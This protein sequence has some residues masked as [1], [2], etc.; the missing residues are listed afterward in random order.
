MHDDR[1]PAPRHQAGQI[2]L[3]ARGQPDADRLRR[4]ARGDGGPHHGDD[5]DLHAG[6]CRGR[7]VHLGQAGPWTDIYGL[8]AT[9]YHAITGKVAAERDR[10]HAAG[11]LRA[12]GQLEAA[13][14][15]ARHCWRPSMPASRYGPPI[16]RRASPSGARCCACRRGRRHSPAAAPRPA[17]AAAPPVARS[18]EA[19]VC[20]GRR[21]SVWAGASAAALLIAAGG[22]YWVGSA[23]GPGRRPALDPVSRATPASSRRSNARAPRWRRPS[24]RR[25]ARPRKK[26]ASGRGRSQA[27]SRSEAAEK[28]R[29]EEE[30]AGSGRQ[31]ERQ[32]AEAEAARKKAEAEAEPRRQAEADEARRKA[33]A[34]TAE[35]DRIQQEIQKAREALAVGGGGAQASRGG[36][37]EAAQAPRRRPRRQR[38]EKKRPEERPARRRKPTPSRRPMPKPRRNRAEAEAAGAEGRCRGRREAEGR[39]R[40]GCRG[41]AKA[42][43][44]AAAEGRAQKAEE[45]AAS[46]RAQMAAAST[47]CGEEAA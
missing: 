38:A 26:Q 7:A 18:N 12:A 28:Q 16:G 42:D 34:E 41:E 11:R 1:L 22:G 43:G 10:A 33:D 8:S 4:R 20:A 6:L 46:L 23:R 14:V 45:E 2:I 24:R 27:Q 40:S 15:C 31:T 9:L 39:R 25:S 36:G 21:P 19:G 44:S 47:A 30:H 17:L 29:A 35:R 13:R 5:G 3:D 37:R 32:R